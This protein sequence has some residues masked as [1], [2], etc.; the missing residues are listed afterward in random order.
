MDTLAERYL[1]IDSAAYLCKTVPTFFEPVD[2]DEHTSNN[3]MD[4]EDDDEATD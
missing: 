1:L 3:A 4:D 2:D